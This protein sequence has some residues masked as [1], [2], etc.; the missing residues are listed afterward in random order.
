M[1]SSEHNWALRDNL[2][3]N[4][5]FRQVGVLNVVLTNLII[6]QIDTLLS[7]YNYHFL[8]FLRIYNQFDNH[9]ADVYAP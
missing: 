8:L 9:H 7:P 4:A 6:L 5:S 2:A 1:E 3:R